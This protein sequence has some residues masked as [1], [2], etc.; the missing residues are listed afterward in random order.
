MKRM[1]SISCPAWLLCANMDPTAFTVREEKIRLNKL[2]TRCGICKVYDPVRGGEHP[3]VKT[4]QALWD[5]GATNSV[6]T[7]V[8]VDKLGLSPIGMGRVY[9]PQGEAITNMYL[10]N[11]LLP[12]NIGI[13][14][15][16]VSEGILKGFD[17]LIGMDI[18]SLGDFAI[19]HKNDGT[20]FSFQL[21]STHEYDF[22]KQI[23]NSKQSI[24][25]KKGRR[26]Y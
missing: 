5:T 21:P 4:F 9:T 23:N 25:A 16:R 8:V 24:K 2:I 7:K 15:L 11:L 20:V 22:V 14:S 12:N 6:I 19:T 1:R 3:P 17:V 26:R 18:I 10:V 13:P